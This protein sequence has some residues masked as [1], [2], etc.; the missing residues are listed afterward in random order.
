MSTASEASQIILSRL[1]LV[2]IERQAR[3]AAPG[4]GA[5]VAAIKE[6]QQR[7][8]AY[9]Y[10]DLLKSQRYGA[11]TRFFLDELYGPTDFTQRDAQ[12]ARVVPALVRMFPEEIVGTVVT[13]SELHSLSEALDTRMAVRLETPAVTASSYIRCWQATSSS[14]DR[15]DQIRLTLEIAKQLDRL[16]QRALLR[17]SLRLMRGPARVAGLVELQ[18]FLES[19]F[20]TF[21]AMRGAKEFIDIVKSRE[22]AFAQAAFSAIDAV[23]AGTDASH[24]LELILPPDNPN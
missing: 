4:L 22:Q 2:E 3:L 13:L 12:F 5:R 17:N 18:R 11:A 21:R 20:D 14:L 15:A 24:A 8:F 9:T 6:Y 16:T 10:A 1:G 19:G 23:G 7:R